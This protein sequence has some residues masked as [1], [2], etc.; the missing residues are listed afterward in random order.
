MAC[1]NSEASF[2]VKYV[3]FNFN[4]CTPLSIYLIGSVCE[5]NLS[6]CFNRDVFFRFLLEL[7]VSL[8]FILSVN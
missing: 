6:V 5:I 4:I 1:S 2:S 7:A 8:I 3:F